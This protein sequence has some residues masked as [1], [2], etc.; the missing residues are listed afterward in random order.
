MRRLAVI[1]ALL[2]AGAAHA[3]TA[4]DEMAAALAAQIDAHPTPIALPTKAQAPQHAAAQSA[5]KRGIGPQAAAAQAHA[6]EARAQG[7]AT[8]AAHQAQ[9]AANAA[10]GQA[11]AEAA[12]ARAAQHPHPHPH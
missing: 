1:A 4:H 9:A 10:A 3:D 11:Q 6:D 5:V 8:A 12:K 7:Q 2:V